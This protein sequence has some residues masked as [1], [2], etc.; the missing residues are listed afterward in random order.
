MTEDD[1]PIHTKLGRY[2][3]TGR[4]GRGGMGVVYSGEDVRLKR[5]VAI[6]V[7]SGSPARSHEAL[8]RCQ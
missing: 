8:Q 6:K 3:I 2:R 4:L 7:L 1:V 5:V